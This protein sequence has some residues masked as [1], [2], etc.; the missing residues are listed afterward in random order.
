MKEVDISQQ[1]SSALRNRLSDSGSPSSQIDAHPVHGVDSMQID[2]ILAGEDLS[3]RTRRNHT[4]EAGFSTNATDNVTTRMGGREISVTYV[5]RDVPDSP[6]DSHVSQDNV[7]TRIQQRE[8]EWDKVA[9]RVDYIGVGGRTTMDVPLDPPVKELVTGLQAHELPTTKSCGGHVRES[10]G[11]IRVTPP[12]V[13]VGEN[14]QPDMPQEVTRA[15]NAGHLTTLKGLLSE[16]YLRREQLLVAE[17]YPSSKADV[18]HLHIRGSSQRQTSPT[19]ETAEAS[20][21]RM[22]TEVNSF[23]E[24]LKRRFLL[25]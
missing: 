21:T 25:S 17:R 2:R 9:Q 16:F 7:P 20:L 4:S 10:V 5:R 13:L 12:Y 24:F 8:Q 23:S 1:T 14:F 3:A 18:A 22:Q 19:Q 15:K 6:V 11:G